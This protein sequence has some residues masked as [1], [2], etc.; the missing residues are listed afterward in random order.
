MY[1]KAMHFVFYKI[2]APLR[3]VVPTFHKVAHVKVERVHFVDDRRIDALDPFGSFD[4]FR[5]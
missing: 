5:R 3:F 1:P 4:T 2:G